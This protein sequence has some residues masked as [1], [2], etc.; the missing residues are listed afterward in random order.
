MSNPNDPNLK[1]FV[2]IDP[3]HSFP[4]QNLPYGVFSTK[5]NPSLK[6][7]GTRIGNFVVDLS[8]LAN[9]R[10]LPLDEPV[11]D[12]PTLNAFM[13][14]GKIKWAETRQKISEL[15]RYDN[16]LLR[17]NKELREKAFFEINDII[18]HLPAEIG[19]Y[20]DFY[21]S[22]EH[23]SNVGAMFRDKN[24]PLLP[25]WL[26]LPVGYHGRASS[27]VV[28]GHDIIRPLGQIKEPTSETPNLMP[29][30]N[31][32]FEL[33]MACFIGTGNK[34][35]EPLSIKDAENHI[36]GLVLM[37]DWSAR[38]IQKWE[39]V[40]LGPFTAKNFATSIS[41]W[42]ISLEA[43]EPFRVPSVTQDPLPLSYLQ[44]P[45]GK[46]FSFDIE[47]VVELKTKDSS[48]WHKICHSNA[49]Y[50]YWTMAQQLTHH[51]IT[52]CNLRPGDLLA[53]GTIS[54]PTPDSFGSMLELAWG[55]KNP[56]QLD[57]N[58]RRTFLED[59]DELR[60]TGFCQSKNYRIGFGEV[61]GKILPAYQLN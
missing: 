16:P 15:L 31:L 17:D 25:N 46:E 36:F 18:M 20:T 13:A 55:G 24:N 10:L 45:N 11:F 39:Y 41:P 37:N 27:I 61:S 33:E 23:A 53:T 9:R 51:T 58:H 34:M 48:K 7:I 44:H 12:F 47:L 57:E 29:S 26:Y 8:L 6:R 3:N 52:G 32:D 5:K 59:G 50:L 38:D 19:D 1:S 43:L 35:G 2:A 60:I 4:I 30:R 42:I 21:S 14:L 28:S 22:K 49:K 56:I 40:P 54:G